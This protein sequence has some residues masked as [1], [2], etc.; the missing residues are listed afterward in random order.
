LKRMDQV[1]QQLD[2]VLKEHDLKQEEGGSSS[3][4]DSD[5][6]GTIVAVVQ[7][8]LSNFEAALA[9]DL[10]MPRA[11]ASLFGVVKAAE[12][13]FK[14]FKKEIKDDADSTTATPLDLNGLAAAKAAILQM[15]KVFGV[16]YEVPKEKNDDG[17]EKEEEIVDD[18]IPEEVMVLV[19][20]R[21]AAKDAKDWDG[22]DSLRGQIT[23][24]GF[25]VKDVKGGEPIVTRI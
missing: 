3:V 10:S 7:K 5:N 1:M 13:E 18:S 2:D 14:R 4:S 20:S 21:T 23:E 9:D 17:T 19:M 11:A 25:A 24:L 6:D 12:T 22:A 16:F 15:D 8:E